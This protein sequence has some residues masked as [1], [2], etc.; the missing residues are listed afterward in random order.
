MLDFLWISTKKGKGSTEVYPT[1]L[2]IK[3][4]D[5][6]VR[7]GDFYAIWVE[8]RGLW[9]TD[10]DDVTSLIDR[11][12]DIFADEY[13]KS[14][15]EEGVRVLYMRVTDNGVIDK[16]HKYVKQQRRDNYKALDETLIFSNTETKK[17]DYA[18]KRLSYPLQPGQTPGYDK[19]M[20]TL[21]SPE[22]RKK[23]EWCI[24]SV[25]TGDS[26]SIQKFLVF[27]GGPGT[28]KGTVLQII[29]KL[30][31]GYTAKFDAKALGSSGAAFAL[32][33]FRDNP[34]V[35]IQFDGD[36]SRIEDNTRL[37][38]II[39]HEPILVNEKRKTQYVNTFKCFL[40]MG[41]NKPVKI[42]DAKS[43][44]IRRLIDCSPTGNKLKKREYDKAFKS[45]DFELGA[46][47]AHCKDVY[48]AD[49]HAYDDYKPMS[50]MEASNDFYNFVLDSYLIFKRD[51]GITKKAAWELYK[52][53]CDDA[54]VTFSYSLRPFAEELKNYFKEYLD[55]GILEDGT[56]VRS[57]YYGFRSDIFEGE[58]E[59]EVKIEP[60]EK[61]WLEFKEQPS[62]F[63]EEFKDCLAQ[64]VRPNGKLMSTWA[65]C[66][67]TLKDIDTHEVHHVQV[68]KNHI[69]IDFDIPDENGN[70][71][72]EKNIEAASKWPPTYAELSKSGQGIHLHYI[73]TGNIEELQ[74][75]YGDHI[76]VKIPIGGSSI[77]RKLTKCVNLAFAVL[78]SGL[79]LKE[80]KKI[81]TEQSVLTEQQLRSFIKRAINKEHHGY[82]K[83]EVD[84][85]FKVL[86]DKYNSGQPYDLTNM[87]TAVMHFASGSS[88][89]AL[90]CMDIVQKMHFKSKEELKATDADDKRIVFV[91]VEV[92]PNL[93][94]INWKFQGKDASVQRM[95]NPS[96]EAVEELFRYR[97]IGFNNK[98]YDNHI[99]YARAYLR[100][101]EYQLF[102][103]SQNIVNFKGKK[104]PYIFNNANNL[105][106]TDV[107]DFAATKQSLKK[108]EIALGIHHLEL[109]IPWDKP[110]PEDQWE[111]VAK[112]CDND[113]L[114]TEA[115][116]DYLEADWTARLILAE[117]TGLTPNDSTNNLSARFIFGTD[118]HPQSKFN[119]RF[120]GEEHPDDIHLDHIGKWEVDPEYTVF[121]KEGRPVFPGYEF[122]IS[123][124]P[125]EKYTIPPKPKAKR[126]SIY[127]GEDPQEGGYVYAEKDIF[128]DIALLDIA[129]M[130][131]HS[132]KAE[133]LF[134]EYTDR[135]YDL[136]TMRMLIKHDELDKARALF[137][138]KLA[139]FL[140]DEK[141]AKRLAYALKI[142]INSAY[143]E[144]AASFDNPFRDRRNIDNI[145][146]KRGALFMINLKHEVQ[147][148]GFT[149]AHIKTDSIK[150]PD[151]TPEIIEFV[152]DY[153]KAY[154]YTFE[155]EATYDRM[156][157]VN[158][159]VYIAKYKDGK[160]TATG[161]Q[162]QVPYVFKSLFS[163]EPITFEDCC[164]VKSVS[165]SLY[166]D[167]NENLPEGEHDYRFVGR[168]GQFTPVKAGCG[169]GK[170][171]VARTAADGSGVKYDSAN[172]AK[173]YR[174][175]E[176]DEIRGREDRMELIDK[177]L[178]LKLA[179]DAI[180][181]I[182]KYGDYDWFVSDDPYEGPIFVD[183]RPVY[184]YDLPF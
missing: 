161:T 164:E 115:V 89:N 73:Y 64:T 104:N 28:G 90:E 95:I 96:P 133:N 77:R 170:L 85:I 124:F 116:F 26:K 121:D 34:L 129:S 22:E 69:V 99:L 176:S 178:Y 27:Y 177:T 43:G 181:E 137:D 143:G 52:T 45:V 101:T 153:G 140:T 79:P 53:Y 110:V 13:R 105:S 114:S 65:N 151:A 9:S 138:G 49:P 130:H 12:L 142:V 59:K 93:L 76:E 3:S 132:V 144:T 182:K 48:L 168:V 41:S 21:Y 106:Y 40:F 88:N 119:Y 18:S 145:V 82:T 37:N 62:L 67:T 57:Y 8:D 24:G 29:E 47:A 23:I 166:L 157:L 4:K 131:P 112:Y 38:T 174:W 6:M 139:K 71:S 98:R 165:T 102:Q 118:R 50:M 74:G 169:G 175:L 30:F 113:V 125:V 103:L 25:V 171:V 107:Y 146:A 7:G 173:E 56:R 32:E 86:E 72:L 159:A 158:D 63:D 148:R 33:A 136:V 162:F 123:G 84:F 36:L 55:R 147:R 2:S 156:C 1:F 172:G 78:S 155:H 134:G 92:F 127:R 179:S 15:P 14:H 150:I 94:L 5:L 183:G 87:K 17:E 111:R 109:G 75:V 31:S 80:A 163:K 42:T 51:N 35:G 117:I 70:K 167:M 19:L 160:W 11:E 126:R 91:D 154:G 128:G 10:E 122:D 20:S 83:P 68:P 149:V 135:F 16:W 120:M 61:S 66:K 81:V 100:Y 60:K 184:D 180:D 152:C 108:W 39:S 44:L 97:L 141:Q 58:D 46:I 54:R